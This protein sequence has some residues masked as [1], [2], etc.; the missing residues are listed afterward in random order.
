M[1]K[2]LDTKQPLT[3]DGGC[4]FTMMFVLLILILT[5]VIIIISHT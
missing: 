5:I 4:L 1:N 3:G 2:K